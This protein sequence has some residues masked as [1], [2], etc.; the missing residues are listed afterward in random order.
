MGGR[1]GGRIGY[2]GEGIVDGLRAKIG[3]F[4]EKVS[5]IEVCVGL[6]SRNGMSPR[7]K[8][9]VVDDVPAVDLET[10]PDGCSWRRR[11]FPSDEVPLIE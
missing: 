6:A 9:G 5:G 1:G 2:I 3:R 11:R 4:K 10:H 8:S 7:E